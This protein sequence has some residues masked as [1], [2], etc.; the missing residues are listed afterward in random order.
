MKKL[1]IVGLLTSCLL[2]ACSGAPSDADIKTA[3]TKAVAEQQK[4][5]AQISGSTGMGNMLKIEYTSVKKIGCKADGESAYRCDVETIAK[6][7][8][9][10]HKQTTSMRLIK[11]SD[12]WVAGR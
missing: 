12:G 11:G 3:L 7:A 6:T 4:M 2:A 9:G 8:M 1:H 5:M 10:E